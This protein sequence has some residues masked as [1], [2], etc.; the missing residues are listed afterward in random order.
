MELVE[1]EIPLEAANT[2]VAYP[3]LGKSACQIQQPFPKSGRTIP[4][5]VKAARLFR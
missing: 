3:R 2:L 1:K 5:I 4:G